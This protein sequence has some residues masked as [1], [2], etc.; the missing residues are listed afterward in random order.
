MLLP[1]H[2]CSLYILTAAHAQYGISLRHH[3]QDMKVTVKCV[4]RN[5]LLCLF[6]NLLY[7]LLNVIA[8]C[9]PQIA[10]HLGVF[11]YIVLLVGESN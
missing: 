3:P 5:C 7:K 6:T 4:D 1:C 10:A 9:Q 2:F 8:Y 11:N